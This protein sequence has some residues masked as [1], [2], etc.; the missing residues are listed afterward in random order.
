MSR[1]LLIA[2]LIPGLLAALPV[3]SQPPTE[4]TSTAAV[5]DAQNDQLEILETLYE[6]LARQLERQLPGVERGELSRRQ[7]SD[8]ELKSLL[9]DLDLPESQL[10]KDAL[11]V[12]DDLGRHGLLA[13]APGQDGDRSATRQVATAR[14]AAALDV[15]AAFGGET[16]ISGQVFDQATGLPILFATVEIYDSSGF[17]ETDLLTGNNGFY[18]ASGLPSGTYFVSTN[19]SGYFNEVY[20]DFPCDGFCDVTQGTP[21]IV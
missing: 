15:A 10:R 7:W 5:G 9:L 16:G 12:L 21:V 2:A 13:Q 19:E 6:R 8:V 18:Q 14:R 1:R 3:S 11:A 20:D 17:L 4:A